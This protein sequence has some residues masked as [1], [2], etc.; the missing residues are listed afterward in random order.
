MIKIAQI[1]LPRSRL[2]KVLTELRGGPSGGH[3]GVIKTLNE[4]QQWY[5]WLQERNGVEKCC[6]QFDTCAASCGP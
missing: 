4:V 2:K 1:I 6:H 3:L 5:Y